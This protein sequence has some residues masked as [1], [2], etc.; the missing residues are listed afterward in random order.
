MDAATGSA[1]SVTMHTLDEPSEGAGLR[2]WEWEPIHRHEGEVY[3]Q[4]LRVVSCRWFGLYIHW[5]HASDDDCLHDHPWPFATLI[6]KG[7]YWEYTIA[8]TGDEVRRWHPPLAL[9]FRPARWLHR[10]EVDPGCLPVTMVLRGPRIRRW[11]FKTVGGWVPWPEYK[12]K[13][14]RE[15]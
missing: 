3:L 15:L 2:I 8:E 13:K 10:V 5:F 14:F 9:R 6:L 1:P 12:E 7:G 4:R 11:G